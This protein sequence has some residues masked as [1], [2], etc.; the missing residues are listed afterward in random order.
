[1]SDE[2]HLNFKRFN[3]IINKRAAEY[4]E[5]RDI[6]IFVET[7]RFKPITFGYLDE[8]LER[9]YAANLKKMFLHSRGFNSPEASQS[10]VAVIP[11]AP[12][13]S[14]ELDSHAGSEA[15][16]RNF[17]NDDGIIFL[18][19]GFIASAASWFHAF[20][21]KN[22]AYACLSYMYDDL[23]FYY[24]SEYE[25]RLT[26]KLNAG[27]I[28][29]Q[30]ETDRALNLIDSIVKERISKYNSQP[31]KRVTI[32]E[33]DRPKVLVIDQSYGD[34]S[35]SYGLADDDVFQG[36]LL[37]A[38]RENPDS[39]IIVKT[40]PD[41]IYDEGKRSG[42]FT[43]LNDF[44]N[45][46]FYK[47][48]IN[49]YCL[50]DIADK[51]Y[52]GTSGVGMEALLAG[53]K[54]ICFGAPFYSGWGLTEDRQA[55]P[56]RKRNRSLAELFHFTYIWY[57]HYHTP[58]SD[59][60][61]DIENALEYIIKHRTAQIEGAGKT[62]ETATAVSTITPVYN[63][64]EYID[65]CISSLRQ[66]TLKSVEIIFIND[67]STDHSLDIIKRHVA[68]DGRVKLIDLP[69][70]IGQGFARNQGID[71]AVG[72][73]VLFVDADDFLYDETVLE[74]LYTHAVEYAAD[75]SRASKAL[76][77]VESDKGK[78]IQQRMDSAEL[79]FQKGFRP[80]RLEDLPV[81]MNNRHFWTF[82]YKRQFLLD[83]NIKFLTTQWEER[84]FLTK[85]LLNANTISDA[86]T[87]AIVYRVRQ[88]STAR[89]AK[90]LLDLDRQLSNY[91]QTVEIFSKA[92]SKADRNIDFALRFSFSQILHTIFYGFVW[93]VL[94]EQSVKIQAQYQQ[95]IKNLLAASGLSSK[96]LTDIPVNVETAKFRDYTYQV[97]FELVRADHWD[98][99]PQIVAGANIAASDVYH[100]VLS[101]EPDLASVAN[102]FL[103]YANK[104]LVY[105]EKSLFP[106]ARP[107]IILHIGSSKSGSTFL[108][109]FCDTNRAKLLD[110]GIWYPEFGQFWQESR[111]HKQAGHSQFIQA[112]HRGD[113]S[114][115]Q[116]LTCTDRL[117]EKP[118]HTVLLSSE[119]FFLMDN[120]ANLLDYLNDFD[121]S[122]LAYLRRQDR[123]ANSQYCEFVAGG[124]IGKV[125]VDIKSWLQDK[126]TVYRMSYER[127]LGTWSDQV[128]R[129][130]VQV[131]RYG[132]QYFK[133]GELIIDF[134]DA[135]GVSD[136]LQFIKPHPDRSNSSVM[137]KRHVGL[138]QHFNALDYKSNEHYLNFVDRVENGLRQLGLPPGEACML[139]RDESE[140][141]L[142]QHETANNYVA[143]YYL[144][145]K[146]GVPLFDL[147]TRTIDN[148][149]KETPLALEEVSIFFGA[150]ED[151][152]D[153]QTAEIEKPYGL[154]ASPRL[155]QHKCGDA[156]RKGG[157]INPRYL[158]DES[159]ITNRGYF[160]WRGRF[161]DLCARYANSVET[162]ALL[163]EFYE[164]ETL[165]RQKT[166]S[167][168]LRY[169]SAVFESESS[170]YGIFQWR[171]QLTPFVAQVVGKLAGADRADQ[172][173]QDPIAFARQF[174]RF[175][176]KL[177]G[178]IIYPM[179]EV[180]KP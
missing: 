123:W 99:V 80:G 32:G 66:Q 54:V 132:R 105:S 52:V 164:N 51:V 175:S 109:H 77:L 49:P 42:Y 166:H 40:H 55:V 48:A 2:H 57:T 102:Q 111:P 79:P 161:K 59:G 141:L 19:Q 44:E 101:G 131:R 7:I 121:V 89:R 97:L 133:G 134:L 76:E 103:K 67:A 31:I 38:I 178:R 24:M 130:N 14:S 169:A 81:L 78:T 29:A 23:A 3:A 158:A 107:K 5:D 112:A 83:N 37:A 70:N 25:S 95:R 68:E 108:Q 137:S 88:A 179:G 39:D 65:E 124:A 136:D 21:E 17:P 173:I 114:L 100:Y 171:R 159:K 125:S 153:D 84:P 18:E 145:F 180:E 96:D 147:P 87:P 92:L 98:L 128:G 160:R 27:D 143:R 72:D 9:S 74:K 106:T 45:V 167:R 4:P 115:L 156:K 152:H 62:G 11:R 82:F 41:T 142:A 150:Y 47:E 176:L 113:Q 73:Y 135:I 118:V 43:G 126:K 140:Q 15:I 90:S 10:D 13:E 165:Y 162:S 163:R 6:R 8:T 69:K 12:F 91:E 20:D 22:P 122:V 75:M 1:M 86:R 120:P 50:F 119:A 174:D 104:R 148:S 85:A 61:C 116:K 34:A 110:Y 151:Y 46:Y 146:S 94:L 60:S 168:T 144:G 172:F 71:R 127:L 157:S 149:E 139:S 170:A 129:D 35:T 16:L 33:D 53:K 177:I 26:R 36:M 63:A 28:L 30:E 93:N 58:Q 154:L 155:A 117:F 138:M 56:H 64:E